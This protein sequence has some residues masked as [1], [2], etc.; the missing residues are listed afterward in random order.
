MC[1]IGCSGGSIT[2]KNGKYGDH[3]AGSKKYS[4]KPYHR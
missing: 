2:V 4:R 3:P 1:P